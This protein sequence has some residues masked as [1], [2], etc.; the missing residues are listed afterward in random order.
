[1]PGGIGYRA[2]ASAFSREVRAASFNTPNATFRS[3]RSRP[4]AR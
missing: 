4:S 2:T 1:M 3:S